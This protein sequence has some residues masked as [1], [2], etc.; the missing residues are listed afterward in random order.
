[1]AKSNICELSVRFRG[2]SLAPRLLYQRTGERRGLYMDFKFTSHLNQKIRS[3]GLF[4]VLMTTLTGC[5]ASMKSRSTLNNQIP[6]GSDL[7]STVPQGPAD[8]ECNHFDAADARLQGKVTT[9]YWN[10]QFMS[11]RVRLR[12]TGLDAS[13]ASDSQVYVRFFRWK[14]DEGGTPYLDTKPLQFIIEKGSSSSFPISGPMTSVSLIEVDQFRSAAGLAAS[15]SVQ[16][17]F[18]NVVL[19]VSGVDYN[20][21]AMK[22]VIYRGST[23][24]AQADFLIPSY[25]ANPSKYAQTHPAVLNA[26]HPFW[27]QRSQNLSDSEWVKRAS[28]FCF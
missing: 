23:A 10:G 15:A 11:D 28:G 6:S 8:V 24:M 17:F 12:L 1:M 13:F 14:T 7:S 21:Q 5:G 9:Y 25:T 2:A 27:S 16:E 3:A 19:Q 26:I 20:W 18:D 4:I 22:A